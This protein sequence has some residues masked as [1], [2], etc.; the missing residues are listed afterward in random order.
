MR[1]ERRDEFTQALQSRGSI[2]LRSAEAASL[3]ESLGTTAGELEPIA[4]GDHVI[5]GPAELQRLFDRLNELDRIRPVRD[6]SGA[7]IDR[8]AMLMESRARAPRLAGD[9]RAAVDRAGGDPANAEVRGRAPGVTGTRRRESTSPPAVNGAQ[10]FAP[11]PAEAS[12]QQQARGVAPGERVPPPIG[13]D[14]ASPAADAR[15]ANASQQQVGDANASQQH[16][17]PEPMRIVATGRSERLGHG[18]DA[19]EVPTHVAFSAAADSELARVLALPTPAQTRGQPRVR[20]VESYLAAMDAWEARTENH[21]RRP[22][23]ISQEQ[24]VLSRAMEMSGL[25]AQDARHYLATGTLPDLLDEHGAVIESG[26]Q[27][28]TELE[29]AATQRGSWPAVNSF[30]FL[31]G[32]RRSALAAE[33]NML[34]QNAAALPE[35]SEGRLQAEAAAE[36]IRNVDMQFNRGLQA[37]YTSATYAR[38]RTSRGLVGQGDQLDDRARR[39]RE[40]GDLPRAE[41]LERRAQAARDQGARMA[42]AEAE[43]RNGLRGTGWNA[44]TT[45]RIAAQ[46]QIARGQAEVAELE[47]NTG[48]PPDQPPAVLTHA[49]GEAT[50][51]RVPGAQNLLARSRGSDPQAARDHEQLALEGARHGALASFHRLHLDRAGF[52]QRASAS[53]SQSREG[54]P[55]GSPRVDRGPPGSA[56]AETGAPS[57]ATLDHRRDYLN[58]RVGQLEAA[59]G[60]MSLYGDVTRLRGRDA[61]DAQ[62]VEGQRADVL[63]ELNATFGTSLSSDAQ[64]TAARQRAADA[65]RNVQNASNGL[66]TA[67]RTFGESTESEIDTRSRADALLGDAG[68]TS[69]EA[70]RDRQSITDARTITDQSRVQVEFA[71]GGERRAIGERTRLHT[72]L[73]TAEAQANRDRADADMARAALARRGTGGGTPPATIDAAY[74]R[75]RTDT[76]ASVTRRLSL[77]RTAE[78]SLRPQELTTAVRAE[79]GGVRID[80]ARWTIAS[81]ELDARALAN[82]RSGA[83]GK[84]ARA[85]TLLNEADGIRRALPEGAE[86]AGLAAQTVHTR[87][88]LAEAWSDYRPGESRDQIAAART[89]SVDI[90][91]SP[92]EVLHMHAAGASE[93][94]IQRARDARIE[95]RDRAMERI[96]IAAA[97]SL[98][99]SDVRLSEIVQS[100]HHAWGARDHLYRAAHDLLDRSF[101]PSPEARDAQRLLARYD[102]ALAAIPGMLEDAAQ[103]LQN[104][105]TFGAAQTRA[106][107]RAEIAM[108]QSQVSSL[109]SGP[110]WFFTAGEFDMK[111][112]MA[113]AGTE[114]TDRRVRSGESFTD[115]FSGGA[116]DLA[117]GWNSAVAQDR[118]FDF[119]DSLRIAGDPELARL[120]RTQLNSPAAHAYVQSYQQLHN[121]IPPAR[122][123]RRDYQD[124]LTYAVRGMQADPT[125]EDRATG[126][127]PPVMYVPVARALTGPVLSLADSRA[128]LGDRRLAVMTSVQQDQ[129]IAA[130]VASL[131]EVKEGQWRAYVNLAG[132]VV[133]GFI[134]TG[135]AGSARAVAGAV[136][137]ANVVRVGVQGANAARM[138][139]TW[140]NAARTAGHAL[141]V[142]TAL[143]GASYG[144]RH[145]FGANSTA[146][147]TFDVATNFIPFAAMQRASGFGR[148]A[149]G[150]EQ[151][152][153]RLQQLG[154]ILRGAG[155]AGGQAVFTAAVVNEA[156]QRGWVRSELGQMAL[157]LGLNTLMAGGMGAY[158]ARQQRQAQARALA[159]GIMEHLAPEQRTSE[160]SRAVARDVDAFLART[161]DRV[162]S[163][164]H[165]GELRAQLYE[166][167][168]AGESV[169]SSPERAQRRD[170]IDHFVEA[171]RIERAIG[172]SYGEAIGRE[173]LSRER[174][175]RLVEL[176]AERLFAARGGEGRASRSQAYRDAATAIAAGFEVDVRRT[177]TSAP[178]EA[179][180]YREAQVWARDRMIASDIAHGLTVA[181]ENGAPAPINEAQRAGVERVLASELAPPNENAPA[182]SERVA[183]PLS[184]SDRNTAAAA[185][186]SPQS[187]SAFWARVNERLQREAGLS[188]EAADRVVRAAERDLAE[189]G[190][191]LMPLA[192]EGPTTAF[193][194]SVARE[195]PILAE[196]VNGVSGENAAQIQRRALGAAERNPSIRNFIE[197]NGPSAARMVGE[198]GETAFL[199]AFGDDG[200]PAFR[201]RDILE[202]PPQRQ[203]ELL[204]MAR[205]RPDDVARLMRGLDTEHGQLIRRALRDEGAERGVRLA[206]I[207]ND[208]PQG[209]GYLVSRTGG[210]AEVLGLLRAAPEALAARARAIEPQIFKRATDGTYLLRGPVP[211]APPRPSNAELEGLA[212]RAGV[213][214]AVIDDPHA[215]PR[216]VAR[217]MAQVRS[218]LPPA[219]REA[220]ERQIE[221]RRF[222][223]HEHFEEARQAGVENPEHRYGRRDFQNW[224]RAEARV[225]Q[226]AREGRPLTIDLLRQAHAEATEGILFGDRRG[227]IR[228]Q[229]ADIARQGGEGQLGVQ[230]VSPDQLA[231]MRGNPDLIV[232]ELG[233][234]EN[235]RHRVMVEYLPPAQVEARLNE[236]LAAIDRRLAAGEDP[237][238]VAADAQREFV[239][240]HPF[241]D[242]NGRMSRLVMDYVLARAG[243]EPSVVRDPNVDTVLSPSAWREEV[244]LGQRTLFQATFEAWSRARA[245][246]PSPGS[247]GDPGASGRSSRTGIGA[248]GARAEGS[249]SA[250]ARSSEAPDPTRLAPDE[251]QPVPTDT[252]TRRRTVG[253]SGEPTLRPPAGQEHLG[254][255]YRG[256]ER[257][258]RAQREY[259]DALLDRAANPPAELVAREQRLVAEHTRINA[260]N[261]RLLSAPDARLTPEQR[262][263]KQQLQA[264]LNE[265]GREIETVS[266]ELARDQSQAR[267]LAVNE[268]R[269]FHRSL[270]GGPENEAAARQRAD[271][272]HIEP[273]AAS[274]A[275]EAQLRAWAADFYRLVPNG[276]DPSGVRLVHNDPRP[277]AGRNGALNVGDA[278]TAGVIFHELGHY[279][280]YRTPALAEA[281]RAWV[282]ARSRAAN[283]GVES[284]NALNILTRDNY[285]RSNEYAFED[286]FETAYIGKDY[287]AARITEVT[288]V[289]L[290]YFN[291][292][293][294]MLQLYQRDPEHF[295]FVLGA[296]RP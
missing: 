246:T 145:L 103:Q 162:P 228:T 21:G 2:D 178:A 240:I 96:G 279:V 260:E 194:R 237:I 255:I 79:L 29:N 124:F 125:P 75:T 170:A 186:A 28:L 243:L 25:S 13:A 147:R 251:Q 35:G 229:P 196:Q 153:T 206:A 31:I 198:L 265:L 61:L 52:F 252:H 183:E 71:A 227:R 57:R 149:A 55:P 169:A 114:S 165:L 6:S 172:A 108:G 98:A 44:G 122:A 239:S 9:D 43:Y 138:A 115:R 136:E 94:E 128:A 131:N 157:G 250:E 116:R 11:R 87:S 118:R 48:A 65:D 226:A 91:F 215:N 166:R 38:E 190:L 248:R 294:R 219:Q 293:E 192:S 245:E 152:A 22:P 224:Q 177:A 58:A 288:T 271:Q 72:E 92:T 193:A 212:R 241:S 295:F 223:D 176:S 121:F 259:I 126:R 107:G 53:G 60:R 291:T 93:G 3:L 129:M 90:T 88:A 12:E 184:Q 211:E 235:G 200:R 281:A 191:I 262:A 109:I 231:V 63:S 20:S 264:R 148:A 24:W 289:G 296:I 76:D 106:I 69:G 32:M 119:A 236:A 95:L 89:A 188:P 161:G 34:L 78:G 160:L 171:Y 74:Q 45:Y 146:A 30:T 173:P 202:L 81:T 18:R 83:E 203:A 222:V 23:G 151:N 261:G 187:R 56:A 217:L 80:A 85:N 139:M 216:D 290:E 210:D 84:L 8:A 37:I 16:P 253:W 123:D 163:E 26:E 283:G 142:G 214:P 232:R 62:R 33:R 41:A 266:T 47:R 141:A 14:P 127:E 189:R 218:E 137:T 167:L 17:A 46:A 154:R 135:G 64:L 36:Q 105:Q 7:A 100:G 49:G 159:A 82:G 155:L 97:G 164:A 4:G 180:Q 68:K 282:L 205:E 256:R 130:Q 254:V 208:S 280:E 143:M 42:F 238:A 179:A 168:G 73:R 195:H 234:A 51:N 258:P 182:L 102:R 181:G 278:P 104:G 175:E 201:A 272:L 133:V 277:E 225:M 54:G 249:R 197:S 39:A 275:S 273:G 15:D 86:R 263:Q 242:G 120:R 140:A 269:R 274:R 59:D 209:L 230:E 285:Y 276:P 233:V 244:R 221:G 287:G 50:P 150:F 134:L 27:R 67:N 110:A 286:H 284:R 247:S 111:E 185:D 220:L 199:R 99:R 174:V 292:P 70:R 268:M 144:M 1:V 112:R 132:E 101:N 158:A 207:A 10:A 40:R 66:R 19:R 117:E 204:A 113:G 267:Q 270:I 257:M 156:A 213:D 5:E 77:A